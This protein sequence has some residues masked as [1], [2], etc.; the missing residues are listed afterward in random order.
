MVRAPTCVLDRVFFGQ[1]ILASTEVSRRSGIASDGDVLLSVTAH[2][3]DP[4][5]SRLYSAS[6]YKRVAEEDLG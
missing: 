1:H 2:A 5:S 3:K 4:L 6:K